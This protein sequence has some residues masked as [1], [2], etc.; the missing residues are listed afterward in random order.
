[1]YRHERPPFYA[2]QG[3]VAT[4]QPL[5]AAAGLNVL[6]RGGNAVDA[7]IATAIALTVLQPGSNDIG[8]DLFAIVWDGSGLHGLNASGRSPAALTREVALAATGGQ[9]GDPAA[10][11]GGAQADPGEHGSMPTRGWLPVTVP[12]APAGWRDLHA[13]FGALPFADLFTDAIGYAERGYPVS[14]KVAAG[15]ARS[16]R[17]HQGLRGAEF[18]EWGRVFTLDGRA[19]RAGE[20]WRNPAAAGTLRRIAASGADDF[21]RGDIAAALSAYAERTGGLL[22]A[23]DLADHSSTWVAPVS[24]SYRGHEVWELPPNGQGVAA[25]SRWRCWTGWTRRRCRRRSGCTGRS[26]R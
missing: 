8:G 20:W 6:R 19:P 12:G 23:A 24:A 11:L 10:A 3:V 21:Y 14:A 2:P 13:R 26:R 16:V 17:I 15:W 1:M 25:L 7:A 5:A 4:S 22:T 18:A 9:G